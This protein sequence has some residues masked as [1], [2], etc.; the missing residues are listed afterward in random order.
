MCERGT[1]KKKKTSIN[2]RRVLL[3][4]HHEY[5]HRLHCAII[6]KLL[7]V[8][9]RMRGPDRVE[10]THLNRRPLPP[11][12]FRLSTYESRAAKDHLTITPVSVAQD[13]GGC[14]EKEEREA[15]EISGVLPAKWFEVMFDNELLVCDMCRGRIYILNILMLA[16]CRCTLSQYIGPGNLIHHN[17]T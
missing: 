5:E 16:Q 15:K 10:S 3:Q 2:R 17:A 14:G 6:S 9:W 4:G 8:P 13:Q 11:T 7:A 1:E 12:V